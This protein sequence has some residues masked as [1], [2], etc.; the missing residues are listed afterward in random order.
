MGKRYKCS[1]VSHGTL[2]LESNFILEQQKEGHGSEPRSQTS[3]SIVSI[4]NVKMQVP[5]A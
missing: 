5:S 4:L 3:M 2:E 1:A